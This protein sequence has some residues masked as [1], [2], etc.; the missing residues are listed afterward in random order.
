M[1]SNKSRV[2]ELLKNLR[3]AANL[4]DPSARAIVEVM[5][6]SIEDLKDSLVTAVG[7]D[8]L[9]MQGAAQH[10]RKIHQELTSSPPNIAPR[11]Q[12]EQ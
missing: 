10:L 6:L 11:A 12:Q 1:T 5:K 3:E 8:M 9:R 7:E 2:T 4:S